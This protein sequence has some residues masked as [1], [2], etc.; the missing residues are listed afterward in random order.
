MLTAP[1]VETPE[2]IELR[3]AFNDREKAIGALSLAVRKREKSIAELTEEAETWHKR[4]QKLQEKFPGLNGEDK[5]LE[6]P[7]AK[8][9]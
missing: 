9:A 2:M 3:Q 5:A 4:Y 6:K 1:G 8:K 7:S